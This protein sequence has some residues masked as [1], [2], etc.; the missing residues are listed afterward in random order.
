MAPYA[1]RS[2][3][4]TSVQKR[5]IEGYGTVTVVRFG[6]RG[7]SGTCVIHPDE[8]DIVAGVTKGD[9]EW[10]TDEQGIVWVVSLLD[11]DTYHF[12]S[13]GLSG[14]EGDVSKSEL[15][16]DKARVAK[17]AFIKGYVPQ[18]KDLTKIG[19]NLFECKSTKDFWQ[20]TAEG[21]IIRLV[22]NTEV[23]NGERLE[24]APADDPEGFLK[25][26]LAELDLD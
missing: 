18:M 17:R 19:K 1:K 2:N 24:A 13:R 20:V 26:A 22:S 8:L 25:N 15:L 16:M 9:N 11:E 7:I 21:K 23:D 6:P 10:F 5:N 4:E 3:M 12:A 14:L